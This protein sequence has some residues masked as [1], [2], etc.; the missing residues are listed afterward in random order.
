MKPHLLQEW[1]LG[2]MATIVG[3]FTS[4]RL[5]RFT[6]KYCT[7][8]Y[9]N[10]CLCLLN[11]SHLL[12]W[13]YQTDFKKNGGLHL[14]GKRS[15]QWKLNIT[16]AWKS[17]SE[18]ISSVFFILSLPRQGQAKPAIWI[19]MF[20]HNKQRY[21]EI[22]LE[23]CSISLQSKFSVLQRKYS[24][25]MLILQGIWSDGNT[26]YVWC[27]LFVCEGSEKCVCIQ[28]AAKCPISVHEAAG[29][30]CACD[31]TIGFKCFIMS[32]SYNYLLQ[33]LFQFIPDVLEP[34]L[35]FWRAKCNQMDLFISKDL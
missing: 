5:Q 23:W 14:A 9:Y 35:L 2:N 11:C 3:A 24:K 1:C 13:L 33:M 20:V 29:D 6:L 4:E 19:I 32:R 16:Q 18:I 28:Q 7:Y 10:L 25:Y 17:G 31:S 8:I 15:V 34:N 26:Y 12:K 22:L 27:E 30:V 21:L